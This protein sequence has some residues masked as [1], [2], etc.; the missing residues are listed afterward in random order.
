MKKIIGLL[1]CLTIFF[2]L[3]PVANASTEE[4]DY[5]I[6][7][8]S[9]WR[10]FFEAFRDNVWWSYNPDTHYIMKLKEDLHMDL[11]TSLD[12]YEEHSRFVQMRGHL[13]F[14]FNGHIISCTDISPKKDKSKNFITI[15]MNRINDEV[16]SVLR[17]TDSVGGG[18]ITME[19]YR[20]SDT[21]LA[22]LYIY[23][24]GINDEVFPYTVISEPICK[25]IIDD[26]LFQLRSRVRAVRTGGGTEN[27]K[28]HY[29]GTV[30][31]DSVG[32]V[33]INGGIFMARSLGTDTGAELG[34]ELGMRGVN[35]RELT[36][37][38]TCCT[39]LVAQFQS[40][41]TDL[42][43]NGGIFASDG[44]AIHH[45][46]GAYTDMHTY[47]GYSGSEI[48]KLTFPKINGGIF[49]G[50]IGYIGRSGLATSGLSGYF[51]D[52]IPELQERPFSSL[53]S[54]FALVDMK[55]VDSNQTKQLNPSKCT[56]EDV[57]TSHLR[58]T[59]ISTSLLS[60]E[61][62][63]T[64][65][66][67]SEVTHLVRDTSMTETFDVTYSIPDYM[68]GEFEVRTNV[69]RR[70]D[71]TNWIIEDG[72]VNYADYP[73]GVTI[74]VNISVIRGA[75]ISTFNKTY[76][77]TVL[78]EP[79]A[80][81]ITTQPKS[82][83]VKVGEYAK[84]TVTADHAAA[85]QW[86]T[87]AAGQKIPLT[88]QFI[89]MMFDEGQIQGETSPCLTVTADGVSE[90]Q[91]YCEVTGTDGSKTNTRTATT[92][93]GG[94]PQVLYFSGGEFEAGGDATF[95]LW[96]DYAENVDWIVQV[97]QG[98]NT[99]FY[100]LE[101]YA[102]ATGCEYV[103]S[104]KIMPS[105]IYKT[106]V[107]FKNVPESAAR[108]VSTGYEMRNALGKVSYNPEN[109][110]PFTLKVIKPE[111]TQE[112]EPQQCIDGE[113]LTFTFKAK[114]MN[115]VE[116]RF[117]KS[118]ED[119]VAVVYDTD[120]MQEIFNESMFGT[121]FETDSETG[122]STATLVINNAR[123]EMLGYTLCTYARS[124][125]G[126]YL[127]GMAPLDVFPVNDYEITDC[128]ADSSIITVCCPE[129][130]NYTLYIAGYDDSGKFEKI[131]IA[132][133]NFSRGKAEYRTFEGFGTYSQI[134][135][136]LLDEK[137]K[138]LCS[139][140]TD[141]A[142]E[143]G[144][145]KH[146]VEMS[147]KNPYE[148][149]V[150]IMTAGD[151]TGKD[152]PEI[153]EENV[154]YFNQA[155]ADSDG[156]L[157]FKDFTP[158]T[159]SVGTMYVGGGDDLSFE[160]VLMNNTIGLGYIGE[161]VVSY[162]G[163]GDTATIS[164]NLTAIDGEVFDSKTEKV[165]FAGDVAENGISENAF[166]K[167]TKLFIKPSAV[168]V[169]KFAD[170]NGYAYSYIGDCN[171]DDAVNHNDYMKAVLSYAKEGGVSGN[172]SDI[173]MDLNMDGEVTL[174]DVSVLLKYISGKISGFFK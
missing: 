49:D 56:L 17:I 137:F 94:S 76:E 65:D 68:E 153:T 21:Q 127:A 60:T 73:D 34:D 79:R 172:D 74:D 109:T 125:S 97:K 124:S 108:S 71:G 4:T 144:I 69:T 151:Y 159:D 51:G 20:N 103:Q 104:H 150:L 75:H 23:E 149:Y 54:P 146:T 14:D 67:E 62:F 171:G 38:G 131:K 111:I 120:E 96:A 170:D 10:D 53:I 138:P 141:T 18:G 85:Y 158:K 80:A 164:D 88:K 52:P 162:S 43:I 113:D 163:D 57:N 70:E 28:N 29:R 98:S 35:S 167:G 32:H 169:K 1:L 2:N 136:M 63:P 9:S 81:F 135:V 121:R 66:S 93:F 40:R 126:I 122:E 91:F 13:T 22:A 118:D 132:P 6:I 7:Y 147:G 129:A 100:N 166:A 36:A 44:Y 84:L 15:A 42:V 139:Y 90:A 16:G 47:N 128:R 114:N 105:G 134:R 41:P 82:T 83:T 77:V 31:A 130:G 116:W 19:T 160:G 173:I 45:F 5:K 12:Y 72:I 33:E 87:I 123:Y 39:E 107:T 37:F 174:Y 143:S 155:M 142:E 112:L 117:E 58:L 115:E 152:I 154:I 25:L 168:N 89:S 110:V 50:A 106:T 165:I 78:P 99:D 133:F 3:L 30:I 161:R 157:T 86:Y 55:I 145:G 24:R 92:T 95:T 46:H 8:I 11:T 61:F 102:E 101:E 27:I 59:V 64:P 140:Y 119:G 148:D 26:G 48:D 156:K